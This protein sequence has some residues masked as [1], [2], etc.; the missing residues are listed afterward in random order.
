MN[1]RVDKRREEAWE[2]QRPFLQIPVFECP[3]DE[4]FREKEECEDETESRVI[5]IEL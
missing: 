4:Y 2:E 1:S 5:I 3:P